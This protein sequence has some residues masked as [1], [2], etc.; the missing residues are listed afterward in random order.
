MQQLRVTKYDPA[1]RNAAGAYTRDEWT[2]FADVGR[3]LGGRR[4]TLE[5]YEEVERA[6]VRAAIALLREAAVAGLYVRDLEDSAGAGAL[7]E[8]V[9]VATDDL[10]EVVQSLLREAYWCR[11]EGDGAYLHFGWDYYMYVGVPATCPDAIAEATSLGLFVE[12][13][14]SPYLR[15]PDP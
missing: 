13:F 12:P 5:E 8:G 6:Y 11:L 4:V 3:V 2:H 1:L 7:T 15:E 14:V 10:E 9:Y